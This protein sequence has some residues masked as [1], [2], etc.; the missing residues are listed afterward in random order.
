MSTECSRYFSNETF[1]LKIKKRWLIL[2]NFFTKESLEPGLPLRATKFSTKLALSKPYLNHAQIR[3]ILLVFSVFA[4]IDV[5]EP[6]LMKRPLNARGF[7]RLPFNYLSAE[8]MFVFRNQHRSLTIRS[9]GS[10][11]ARR[12]SRSELWELS[13]QELD[14]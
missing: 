13:S 2:R 6:G 14:S 3:L 4:V 5:Y 8:I 1:N 11:F 12:A 7:P 10:V 9:I